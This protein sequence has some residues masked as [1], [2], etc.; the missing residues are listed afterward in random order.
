MIFLF[1]GHN[2]GGWEV[3]KME[4]PKMQVKCSVENCHYNKQ[5]MCHADCLE[6][7]AM[8]GGTNQAESSDS[9]CCKT[10]IKHG[11]M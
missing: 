1:W 4:A 2:T 8:S 6:V 11:T 9:T 7:N 10:F 3:I 5:H